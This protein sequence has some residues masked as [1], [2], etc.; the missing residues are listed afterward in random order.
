[1]LGLFPL[2]SAGNKYIVLAIDHLTRYAETRD[3]KRATAP[4]VAQF[5][6]DQ[7]I[8]RYS[9]LFCVATDRGTAFMAQLTYDVLKLSFTS[10]RKTTAY[11]PETNDSTERI[12]KTVA[13][14]LSMHVNV[15]HNTWYQVLPYITFTYNTAI[16]ETTRFTSFHLV[17]GRGFQTILEAMLPHDYDGLPTPDAEQLT[18]CAAEAR[19]FARL[20][21]TQQQTAVACHYNLCHRQV[22]YH[23]GDIVCV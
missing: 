11:N 14:M 3:P 17:Y 12:N 5:F 16:Q 4:D 15:P 23:L 13:D 1:M 6:I 2:S 21:I 18:Q 20:H 8:L 9:T 7:I 22:E 19:R 10:H